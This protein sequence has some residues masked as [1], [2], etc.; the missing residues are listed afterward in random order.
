MNKYEDVID[1]CSNLIYMIINK[2]FNGFEIEDLYQVG[3]LGVIK[4]YDNYKKN[5]KAKFSTYAYKYIYG[6]IYTYVNSD[7]TIKVSKEIVS[8]YKRIITTRN[9]L[10]QRLMREPSIFDIA[11]FLEVDEKIIVSSLRVMDNVDSLDRKIFSDDKDLSLYDTI[12]DNK[13]YNNID[14]IML[15]DEINKLSSP[16]REIIYLRYYEDMTQ[17]EVSNIIGINQVGVSRIEKKTLKKIR[18]NYQNVA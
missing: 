17:S 6:E 11:S 10:S 2:Y 18:D 5:S 15:R 14:F 8:L 3:V 12:S 1:S 16:A 7:K 9:I 13:E 4:A